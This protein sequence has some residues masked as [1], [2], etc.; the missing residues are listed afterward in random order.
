MTAVIG[1]D[2]NFTSTANDLSGIT[3]VN[4]FRV[5]FTPVVSEVTGFSASRIRAHKGGLVDITGSASGAPA[6][7]VANSQ[8]DIIPTATTGPFRVDSTLVLQVAASCT[9]TFEAL[10]SEV[11]FDV[12]KT[13]D[14]LVSWNFTTGDAATDGAAL[15]EVWDEA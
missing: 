8:V 15:A 14:S 5:S 3:L 13:G 2:G 12:N 10:V 11:S 1:N 9:Y 7:D 4:R 6:K